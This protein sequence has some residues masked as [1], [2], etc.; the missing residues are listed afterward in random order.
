[1]AAVRL[2][3][4]IKQLINSNLIKIDKNRLT[5]TYQGMLLLDMVIV[6]LM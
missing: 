5:T 3:K 6:K 4:E 2:L 1:M